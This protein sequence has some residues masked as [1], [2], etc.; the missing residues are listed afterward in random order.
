MNYL[1]RLVSMKNIEKKSKKDY[2]Y[3]KTGY[4]LF[5]RKI[6]G[7]I[8]GQISVWSG[9]NS[10]GKTAFM[11][12]QIVEYV[13]Q[14]FK[15]MLFSGEMQAHSI[16]N[17]IYRIVAGKKNLMSS[18]DKT[19]Y[20][21]DDKDIMSNIDNY[22]DDKLYI[23]KNEYGTK[24]NEILET[25]KEAVNKLGVQ[26]V[27]LDNLMTLDLRNYDKDKY[28]A[29]SLFAK[30]LANL[31]KQL[32]IHVHMIAHPRKASGYLRKSD[33]SG[34]ADL[35][36]A[37]DNVFIVHRVNEDFKREYSMFRKTNAECFNQYGTVVEICKNREEGIQ[38]EIIPF[39]FLK[40]TKQIVEYN[41]EKD[42]YKDIKKEYDFLD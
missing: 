37:V 21:L 33:I 36:N 16:Q 38:D 40:E 29:Q 31:T 12:Q 6:E 24:S 11:N 35:S 9:L 25:I 7:Y 14:G 20:Y 30:E 18:A 22:F 39:Y 8:L 32:N 26:I 3:I 19:Y 1:D 13:K 28:E 15:V 42:Y 41:V 4:D 34:S 10:S 27:I 5:D 17:T 23:Y 2:K